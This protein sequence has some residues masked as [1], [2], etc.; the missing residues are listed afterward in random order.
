MTVR[1]GSLGGSVPLPTR[2]LGRRG[3][4]CNGELSSVAWIPSAFE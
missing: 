3:W 4:N 2:V 1:S